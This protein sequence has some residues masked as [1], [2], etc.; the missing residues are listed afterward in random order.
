MYFTYKNALIHYKIKGQGKPVLLLHG[1]LENGKIWKETV[2]RFQHKIRFIIPDL[3]GHGKSGLTGDFL[4][5]EEQAE[6]AGRLLEYEGISRAAVIGHSMGGYTAL[7]FAEMFPVKVSGLMLLYS[8][9]FA[10]DE[11][12]KRSRDLAVVSAVKDKFSFVEKAIPGFFAPGNAEKHEKAL[13]KLIRQAQK[14]PVE[15]I[16]GALRGMKLRKDRSGI[17]FS[18]KDYPAF[19][20][21]GEK[22]P[23]MPAW[24]FIEKYRS[25][26]HIYLKTTPEGHMG[27]IENKDELHEIIDTFFE[28]IKE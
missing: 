1:F 19:W 2:R 9:P 17:F 26:P 6:M 16:T 20:V 24:K 23:L 22:D 25:H 12:K 5:M 21:I 11:T 13:Q 7:A 28:L 3:I 15:G 4:T 18:E 14:M 27:F 8:H 10:D